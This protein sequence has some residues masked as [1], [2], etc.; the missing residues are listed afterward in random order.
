M[1]ETR[2]T[3][4]PICSSPVS[5]ETPE[6]SREEST[7]RSSSRRPVSRLSW[8]TWTKTTLC[9]PDLLSMTSTS[10]TWRRTTSRLLKPEPLPER[11]SERDSLRPT[12]TCPAPRPT[13]RLT[14]S[15]ISST[16]LDSDVYLNWNFSHSQLKILIL[17]M[18]F[19]SLKYLVKIYF[20]LNFLFS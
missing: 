16:D 20:D 14:M 18:N 1:R 13:K 6:T 10:R 7:R 17:Q 2:S 3:D 5:P 8:S 15:D 11:R 4:S 19:F 12:G 9:P